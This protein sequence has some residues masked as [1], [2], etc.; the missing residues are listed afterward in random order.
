MDGARHVPISNKKAEEL[1]ACLAVKGIPLSKEKAAEMLW[2]NAEP[3]KA[4]DS[5]NKVVA[6]LKH[7]GEQTLPGLP[8]HIRRNELFLDMSALYCDIWEFNEIYEKATEISDWEKAVALYKGP[9]LSENYYEWS[10]LEEAYYDVRY[11]NILEKLQ[12][13]FRKAGNQDMA[14][15]YK[16]KLEDFR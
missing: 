3:Q 13:A 11:C 9:L 8:L 4:R 7:F 5:L 12:E 10:L 16:M 1:L 15:Y 2:E 6:F 14:N